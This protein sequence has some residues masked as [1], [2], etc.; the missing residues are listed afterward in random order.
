MNNKKRIIL[1]IATILV[2]IFSGYK[3]YEQ[4]QDKTEN[5]IINTAVEE[6]KEDLE[7]IKEIDE[8]KQIEDTK[9]DRKE[10]EENQSTTSIPELTEEDER[11]LEEQ[12]VE[13]EAFELQGEIA[14]EGDRARTWNLNVGNTPQLTY[15]SQIDSR[16]RYYPYTSTRK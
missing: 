9:V 1:I 5:E 8:S 13:D 6:V 2:G 4:N 15:I 12:K 14:Y 7:F 11:A 10:T 16:W 3:F